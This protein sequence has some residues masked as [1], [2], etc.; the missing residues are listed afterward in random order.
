MKIIVTLPTYNEAQNIEPLIE[1]L[2]ALGEEFEV[3]VIDDHSPDGTWQI[4]ERLSERNPRV[5]LLHRVNERGRGT[6]GLAGFRWARDHGADAVVEMDADFSHE[7]RFIPSLLEPIRRGEANIVI[8]SRLVAGG[9]EEG[10]S[11]IRTLITL[12]A[13]A[14]IRL[15]L[16][17][18]IRDCTSG[19]RVFDRRAL[20][21]LPW[22]TMTCR[23]PEIVQEVLWEARRAGL[24]MVERP[25][26]FKERRAGQ[27][28]F[29]FKI[30][31]RSLGYMWKLRMR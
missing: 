12:A 24:R 6:A 19:F 18:P 11:P 21:V 31:L 2:L 8:G 4:V 15:M 25:I 17:L 1:E 5:H 9:K 7:P 20:E 10:R 3:L 27:S 26:V 30:M 28:T 22:E 23:G 16:G 14:Y 13:N 29:N